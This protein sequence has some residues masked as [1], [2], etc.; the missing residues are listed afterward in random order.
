MEQGRSVHM[1]RLLHRRDC[2]EGLPKA[3]EGMLCFLLK[4]LAFAG[5]LPVVINQLFVVINY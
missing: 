5:V 4:S 2:R 3:L 1:R